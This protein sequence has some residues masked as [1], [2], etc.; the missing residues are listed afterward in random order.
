[1]KLLQ[2]FNRETGEGKY[3][4]KTFE[5]LDFVLNEARLH[6]MKVILSFIDNWGYHNGVGQ[7]VDW[8]SGVPE[9]MGPIPMTMADIQVR[10][11]LK[12]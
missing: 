5:K 6:G 4:G 8:G 3:H 10:K 9:R 7:F 1:M 12:L 11:A 2:S